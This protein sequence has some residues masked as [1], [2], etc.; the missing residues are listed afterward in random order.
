M[1]LISKTDKNS[2]HLG[3]LNEAGQAGGQNQLEFKLSPISE[4]TL[5]NENLKY[6]RNQTYSV[7]LSSSSSREFQ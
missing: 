5:Y 7:S 4:L 2:V 3:I 1:A 6:N